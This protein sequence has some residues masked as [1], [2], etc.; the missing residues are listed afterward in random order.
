MSD[1]AAKIVSIFKQAQK[2]E[3]DPE[4][5]IILLCDA[6]AMACCEIDVGPKGI[7]PRIAESFDTLHCAKYAHKI[8]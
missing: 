3:K 6:V 7:F 1:T 4:D 2:L 8:Q 5:T